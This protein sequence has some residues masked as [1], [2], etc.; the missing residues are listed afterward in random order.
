MV[1]LASKFDDTEIL[2]NAPPHQLR[3]DLQAKCFKSDVDSDQRIVDSNENGIPI[4][5]VLIGFQPCFGNLGMRSEEE[6][7]RLAYIGVSPSHRLLPPRCV[8]CTMLAGKSS[9]KNFIGYFQN[10]YNNRISC[11]SVI[12]CTRFAGRSF[13]E[14]DPTT[15]QDIGKINYN[16]LEFYDRPTATTEEATLLKDI[17][18]FMEGEG[19]TLVSAALRSHIPGSSLIELPLGSDHTALKQQFALEHSVPAPSAPTLPSGVVAPGS[20]NAV[21]TGADNTPSAKKQKKVVEISAAQA[22]AL[23][24][25]LN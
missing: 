14:K 7:I 18:S 13:S 8:T 19:P 9:Q 23:G 25:E 24:I 22:E 3:I 6:F 17:E 2:C 11:A 21:V 20:P 4:E 5:L 10:L 16:T 12:T 1:F 15:G